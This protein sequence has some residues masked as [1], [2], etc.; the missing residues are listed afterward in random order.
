M[1]T[2][3]MKAL[4]LL[5]CCSLAA[6]AS[7]AYAAD[8][9]VSKR[10]AINAVARPWLQEREQNGYRT[11]GLLYPKGPAIYARQLELL[12]PL[13]A[14]PVEHFGLAPELHQIQTGYRIEFGDIIHQSSIYLAEAFDAQRRRVVHISAPESPWSAPS[15][16]TWFSEDPS[17]SVSCQLVNFRLKA[18]E[19][20]RLYVQVTQT[21]AA[22]AALSGAVESL[23]A[24]PYRALADGGCD[25]PGTHLPPNEKLLRDGEEVQVP[26]RLTNGSTLTVFRNALW[27]SAELKKIRTHGEP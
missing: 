6:L 8:I 2:P 5:A 25:W 1:A 19:A 22:P 20:P 23:L 18:D 11:G 16:R 17:V 21:T 12:K 14:S 13:C 26:C 10:I 27:E 4:R 24:N 9:P 3:T 15:P 7:N